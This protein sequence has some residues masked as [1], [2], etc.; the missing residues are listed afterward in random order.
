MVPALKSNAIILI[1][2]L[3]AR[4]DMMERGDIVVYMH[5]GTPKIKRI[6]GTKNETL[7]IKDGGIF[8]SEMKI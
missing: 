7:T 8:L 1:D 6:I 5:E 2:T 3:Q 4:I